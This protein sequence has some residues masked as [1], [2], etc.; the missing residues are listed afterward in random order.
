MA[1]AGD[2]GSLTW[3]ADSPE[4]VA[5]F[6]AIASHLQ[7]QFQGGPEP[8]LKKRRLEDGTAA[9]DGAN[10]AASASSVADAAQE[11]VLLSIKD[12]SVSAPQRK[13][14]DLCFTQGFL[15]ARSSASPS[16]VPGMIFAWQDIGQ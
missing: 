14:F 10:G 5:L 2:F 3:C 6:N 4:R 16:P 7:E 9:A 12:I 1:G 13:K 11:P 15:Y 8:A